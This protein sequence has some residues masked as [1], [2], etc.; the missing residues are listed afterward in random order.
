MGPNPL[1]RLHEL[2]LWRTNTNSSHIWRLYPCN[3]EHLHTFH[4][5]PSFTRPSPPHRRPFQHVS[6]QIVKS[7]QASFL[8]FTPPV[9]LDLFIFYFLPQFARAYSCWLLGITSFSCFLKIVKKI[10]SQTNFEIAGF[11]EWRKNWGH[12]LPL[13]PTRIK[14]SLQ[15]S[16]VLEAILCCC[17][18]SRRG[19]TEGGCGGGGVPLL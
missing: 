10:G 7:S 4:L 1:M 19:Y 12:F 14:Y 18:K 15:T 6:M 13:N 9:I 16:P 11:M 17:L 2:F 5:P 3:R 8:P